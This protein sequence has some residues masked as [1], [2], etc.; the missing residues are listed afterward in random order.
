METNSA[1]QIWSQRFCCCGDDSWRNVSV[2]ERFL[3]QDS[4]TADEDRH[5][6]ISYVIYQPDI[7]LP[8]IMKILQIKQQITQL[9]NILMRKTIKKV[10]LKIKKSITFRK[11]K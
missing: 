9:N 10:K 1:G 4:F 5:K 7:I 11:S 8:K 2:P 6:N 3:K